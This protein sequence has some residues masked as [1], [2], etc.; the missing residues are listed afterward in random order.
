MILPVQKVMAIVPCWKES[1]ADIEKFLQRRE[2]ISQKLEKM[3]MEFRL[4][5]LDDGAAGLPTEAPRLIRHESNQGLAQ[6]LIEGYEAAVAHEWESDIIIRIDSQ[7]HDPSRIPEIADHMANTEADALFLPVCYWVKGEV[8]PKMMDIAVSMEKFVRA[9]SPIDTPVIQSM[10]NV[11]FPLG[12]QAWRRDLL[13]KILPRL[14]EGARAFEHMTGKKV[15]WGLDLL[16]MLLAA[17]ERSDKVDFLFGGWSEPWRENRDAEKIAEQA[18]R[19]EV[20]VKVAEYLGAH[21]KR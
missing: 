14:K 20:M 11:R 1:A 5:F 12:F 2:R 15:T 6:T 13:E 21:L 18:H 4:F 7:E 17:H 3:G 8:R 19:A 9:L 16:A 10:Y